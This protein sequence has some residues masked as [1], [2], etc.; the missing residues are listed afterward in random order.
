MGKSTKAEIYKRETKERVEHSKRKGKK[1]K[2]K[3]YLFSDGAGVVET[4]QVNDQNI[5]QLINIQF[6]GSAK[7]VLAIGAIPG[8]VLAQNLEGR[9][10]KRDNHLKTRTTTTEEGHTSSLL[11]ALIQSASAMDSLLS[12]SLA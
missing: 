7:V 2:D 6:L 9:R 5:G 1:E 12:F 10:E 3:G 11:K 4:L 8:I